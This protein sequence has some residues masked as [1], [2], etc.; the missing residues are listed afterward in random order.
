MSAHESDCIE[1]ARRGNQV[2]PSGLPDRLWQGM[3][4]S[5][6]AR[7]YGVPVVAYLREREGS[8]YATLQFATVAQQ[9]RDGAA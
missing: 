9:H 3:H 2:H 5:C 6:W 8:R 1:C 4:D 7:R